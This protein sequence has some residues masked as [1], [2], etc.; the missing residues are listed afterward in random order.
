MQALKMK[1]TSKNPAK[2]FKKEN[3]MQEDIIVSYNLLK[4]GQSYKTVLKRIK[5]KNLRHYF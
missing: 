2:L 4:K 1:M 3:K 5:L